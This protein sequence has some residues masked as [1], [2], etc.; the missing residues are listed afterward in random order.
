MKKIIFIFFLIFA[1]NSLL[2]QTALAQR[3]QERVIVKDQKKMLQQAE[4]QEEWFEASEEAWPELKEAEIFDLTG[5]D[6]TQI[7]EYLAQKIEEIKPEPKEMVNPFIGVGE[8]LSEPVLSSEYIPEQL[9]IDRAWVLG[10]I[11]A[12]LG[13]LGSMGVISPSWGEIIDPDAFELF[14]GWF[15]DSAKSKN[16]ED[17]EK[18]VQNTLVEAASSGVTGTLTSAAATTLGLTTLSTMPLSFVIYALI[19]YLQDGTDV[20]GVGSLYEIAKNAAQKAKSRF[21][22]SEYSGKIYNI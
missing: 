22:G 17:L 11:P 10:K 4:P 3:G 12:L 18:A 6:W 19:R 16:K 14:M 8:T 5:K 13:L 1:S 21:S 2:A 15:V 20:Y 9:W 7:Q